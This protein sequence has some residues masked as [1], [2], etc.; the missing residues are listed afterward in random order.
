M[1]SR[2]EE[3]EM[4]IIMVL[5]QAIGPAQQQ[6]SSCV[7]ALFLICQQISP[8]APNIRLR[9]KAKSLN[10]ENLLRLE[11]NGVVGCRMGVVVEEL[12]HLC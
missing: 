10:K 1:R 2:K 4:R 6:L 12:G 8:L 5:T 3:D 9:I 11:L 7:M